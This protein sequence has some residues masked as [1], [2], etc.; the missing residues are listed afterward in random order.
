[1]QPSKDQVLVFLVVV[2]STCTAHNLQQSFTLLFHLG[3]SDEEI[4]IATTNLLLATTMQGSTLH[5]DA[6]KR[7][8]TS[9]HC[10]H[11]QNQPNSSKIFTWRK[12]W[13]D[14]SNNAF[15]KVN[16][17]QSLPSLIDSESNRA[18]AQMIWQK[19]SIPISHQPTPNT[20]AIFSRWLFGNFRLIAPGSKK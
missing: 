16:D 10:R 18:F 9:I 8:A 5:G 2:L 19:P 7:E 17:A 15:K 6:L 20:N 3:T 14:L 13:E 12:R 4:V 11:R 1:M